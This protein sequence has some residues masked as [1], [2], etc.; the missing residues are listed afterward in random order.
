MT[1]LCLYGVDRIVRIFYFKKASEGQV[2]FTKW[3]ENVIELKVPIKYLSGYNKDSSSVPSKI[4]SLVVRKISSLQ[5]HPFDI[6]YQKGN[7][8]ASLFVAKSGKWTSDLFKHLESELNSESEKGKGVD[9]TNISNH[10]SKPSQ[11]LSILGTGKNEESKG[12][13]EYSNSKE[14][15]SIRSS[16]TIGVEKK[17]PFSILI[18]FT[19]D[20]NLKYIFENQAVS[21]VAGGTGISPMISLLNYYILNYSTKKIKTNSLYLAWSTKDLNFFRVLEEI[22]IKASSTNAAE[23]ISIQLCYTGQESFEFY[24]SN[25]SKLFSTEFNQRPDFISAKKG[26]I[27]YEAQISEV[28]EDETVPCYGFAAIGNQNLC[29]SYENAVGKMAKEKGISNKINFYYNNR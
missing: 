6:S 23:S 15:R 20:T 11:N 3:S 22:L 14:D 9:Q 12:D 28:F 1:A 24:E 5:S 2:K 8:Y 10:L 29:E 17:I 18:S 16:S 27:D 25:P 19:Y 4:T 26:R 7:D 13:H 21:L